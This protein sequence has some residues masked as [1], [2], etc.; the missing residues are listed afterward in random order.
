LQ[1][2][3]D[4]RRIRYRIADPRTRSRL[5]KADPNLLHDEITVIDHALT[6]PW[7][8]DKRYVRNANPLATWDESICPEYNAW[9][10]TGKEN[11]YLSS[12]GYLM[13][14]RKGQPRPDLRYFEKP[15]N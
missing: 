2:D 8:V 11:Y 3:G 15:L 13:P 12:D 7:T 14:T 4:E 1:I 9:V 5:D 10:F 6:R